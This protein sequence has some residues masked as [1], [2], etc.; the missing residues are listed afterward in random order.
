MPFNFSEFHK[1]NVIDTCSIWNIL[2]SNILY[3]AS[4]S[5]GC[6][7]SCTAFVQYECLD[8][9][10]KSINEKDHELQKRLKKEQ[11]KGRFEVFHLE[12]EDLLDVDVLD[13]RK[14]LGKGELSS[15]AFAKRTG[16]AF[17]TD[18]QGARELAA[19]YI[20]KKMVQ[21]V[22]RLLGWLFF[23]Q[24]LSDHDKNDIILEHV[25]YHRPLKKYFEIMYGKALERR[26]ASST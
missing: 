16:Q 14:A 6:H 20:D 2:S 17:I 9:P 24:A 15:I 7:Y 21:T 8:K 12:L 25:K 1:I 3:Q 5:A 4:I 23:N 11:T 13:K 26:L 18:D 22:P 19:S 10:R